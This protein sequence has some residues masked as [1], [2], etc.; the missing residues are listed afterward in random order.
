MK[1]TKLT[2]EEPRFELCEVVVEQ[3]FL[4]SDGTIEDMEPG[5]DWAPAE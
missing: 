4:V 1:T 2:S 3:G 5:D